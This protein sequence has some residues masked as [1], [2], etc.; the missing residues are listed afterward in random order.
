VFG[1]GPPYLHQLAFEVTNLGRR[2][3]VVEL[4][5]VVI[6]VVQLPADLQGRADVGGEGRAD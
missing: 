3:L 5:C 4:P 2:G 1:E 6:K